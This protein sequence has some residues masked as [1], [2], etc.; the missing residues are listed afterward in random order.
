[1]VQRW[2]RDRKV[3]GST[4]C[5]GANRAIKLTRS[6]EPSIPPGQV[7]RVPACMA[8]VKAGCVHLCHRIGQVV[9]ALMCVDCEHHQCQ[10]ELRY[11]TGN[12][13]NTLSQGRTHVIAPGTSQG[14]DV[15][16]RSAPAEEVPLLA[17]NLGDAS[18]G[19]L[20]W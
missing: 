10:L 1:M 9:W 2:T 19:R 20:S 5:R 7:N 3:A 18:V 6:T 13:C 8:G 14:R 17:T 12:Q 11:T 16:L 4:P 15:Q